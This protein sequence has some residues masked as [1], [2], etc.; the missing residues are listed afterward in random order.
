M[1]KPNILLI[2]FDDLGYGD[3]GCYGSKI[4]RSP[5]IDSLAAEGIRFTDFY[6]ASPVCSPSRGAL[7]TG[8]YPKRIGFE[9]F[10]GDI[11]LMP[12]SAIGLGHNEETLPGILKKRGYKTMIVGKWHCGDQREFLPGE[13]GFDSYYGIPYSNDMGRQDRKT[14]KTLDE[15]DKYLPPL[16]LVK[17]YEVIQEQP[18]QRGLIERYTEH[19]VDFI[20]RNRENPFFLYFAPIQ[21]HLPLY[22]PERFVNTS[23]NGDFG[24]CVESVDWAVSVLIHELKKADV[25]DNTLIIITSD[26]GSRGDNGAC[27]GPLRER[28]G[29]TWEGGMRVPCVMYWK[30]V[31]KEA[32]TCAD[33]VCNMDILPTVAALT[34]HQ[35]DGNRK[36]DGIDF[37]H[38]LFSDR[39]GGK[40]KRDTMAYYKFGN[41]EAVR[42]GD[43][44]LHMFK[45]RKA[46]NGLYNLKED[47]GEKNNVYD[48]YPQIVEEL[49]LMAKEIREDMGDLA[50][51]I[52]GKN[53]R[54]PARVDD[55][56]MLTRF[57]P[58]HPYI[59]ALYDKGEAG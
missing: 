26:N 45:E 31:I 41:L 28:K 57:D 9:D 36:I 13:Y 20:R 37:S 47:V 27:N 14:G 25:F 38:I 2:N 21:V 53:A 44:K 40:N 10:D 15:Y 32:K 22:A 52:E 6:S 35:L 1:K 48:K 43:W 24:A 39:A 11:V 51:G 30:E 56:R 46:F 23:L 8:C 33:I 4:N 42:K 29:T 17:D 18:D 54:E 50:L 19:G 55:P 12:G 16:P 7:M 34:G 59:I 3:L 49:S 58:E 5:V